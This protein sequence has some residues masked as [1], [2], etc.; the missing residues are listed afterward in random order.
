MALP[1]SP[2]FDKETLYRVVVNESP[3][4]YLT[5]GVD[6]INR[7]GAY[8]SYKHF[9]MELAKVFREIKPDYPYPTTLLSTCIE[10]AHDQKYFSE[11]LPS[12]TEVAGGSREEIKTFILNLICT[13][14]KA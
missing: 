3:K 12:L 9:C 11:H 4:A 2:G 8:L 7:E 5:K 13:V 1:T 10:S 14:L 6:E